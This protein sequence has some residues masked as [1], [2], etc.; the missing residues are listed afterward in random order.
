MEMRPGAWYALHTRA[1]LDD[2]LADANCHAQLKRMAA[3]GLRD[4][5]DLSGPDVAEELGYASETAAYRAAQHGRRLLAAASAWPWAC[6]PPSVL[7]ARWSAVWL[8]D[9]GVRFGW[10]LWCA[11]RRLILRPGGLAVADA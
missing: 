9:V 10:G 4:L 1:A 2:A 7:Q 3:A 11:G 6:L 8:E 5:Y